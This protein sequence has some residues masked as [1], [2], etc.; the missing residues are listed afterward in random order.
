MSN[1]NEIIEIVIPMPVNQYDL[2]MEQAYLEFKGEPAEVFAA[3]AFDRAFDA[4]V[5]KLY[6]PLTEPARR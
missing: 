1:R 5:E 3:W 6:R 4:A 2:V